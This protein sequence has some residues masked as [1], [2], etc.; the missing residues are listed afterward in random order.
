MDKKIIL[1][2]IGGFLML[3]LFGCSK[4]PNVK[5]KELISYVYSSG[6]GMTGGGNST[7]ISMIDGEVILTYSNAEWWYDDND[8]TEYK[9][10]KAVLT[11]IESVFRQYKMQNWNGKKFT[12]M[13]VADGPS[14]SYSF[15]FEDNTG[16]FFSS[17]VYPA[18]YS[19]K[20]AEIDKV[21]EQYQARGTLEPG[22]VTK[23][24]TAEELAGKNTP[25]NGLVEIAVYE[26]SQDRIC[27]RILNGT[28]E[29]VTVHDS[30]RL[31]RNSDGEI[32]YNESSEYSITVNAASANEE[33]LVS[34]R[35][36]E[37]IYTLYVG[38]YSAEF[39][40]R[41]PSDE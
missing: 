39:E 10:D 36:E 26:Y 24:R 2:V 37:G 17:Q 20:L 3:G 29:D 35:L 9:L 13:F 32:L 41:L 5:N 7:K 1:L 18:S 15:R 38:D 6:G 33:S 12:N 31:V 22:L 27:F 30:V 40:I 34:G 21:I 14:Y 19:K 28:D 4:V 25:D 11:D 8:I 23:E 16:V